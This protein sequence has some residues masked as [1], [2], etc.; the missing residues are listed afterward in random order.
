MA[1]GSHTNFNEQAFGLGAAAG[2][3]TLA[4]AF[5]A[6]LA[7][8]RAQSRA[9]YERMNQD[10]IYAALDYYDAQLD[11]ARQEIAGLRADND[12]LRGTGR[13]QTGARQAIARRTVRER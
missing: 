5:G 4:S 1:G 8:Y 3:L 10:A 11:R 12:R 2:S 9:R 7:N 6:G 13:L